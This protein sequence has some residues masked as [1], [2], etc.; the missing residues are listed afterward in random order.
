[1]AF[2]RPVVAAL[3]SATLATA[4]VAVAGMPAEAAK[5]SAGTAT[6][7]YAPAST[8][9]IHPGTMMYTDGAQCTA[10]FVYTDSAANTYVG[11]AAHCAGTGAATSTDGCDTGSLPLGTKVDFVDN[12]SLVSSGTTVGTGTLVYSSWLTMQKDGTTDPDTCAY[13]DLALVKVDP[14]YV[15][16]VNPS[17]PFWGGPTGINTTGTAAGDDVFS[18]GNSSLR[19]GIELL[20]PKQGASLGDDGNGWSHTVYTVT[21]GIPGDSGSAFLD[22]DGKALGVLSTVAIA[23]L[24]GSNGVGDLAKELAFAQQHSGISGLALVNGTEP[25]SP[26][27]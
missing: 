12:G 21:P 16:T 2:R 11:Y 4:A 23:P 15:S 25:F 5:K 6:V 19:A 18:Y 24:A 14:Q 7:A 17:I 10:N 8:A 26:L 13:N 9:K 22:K 3:A 20:K 1:M 27:L